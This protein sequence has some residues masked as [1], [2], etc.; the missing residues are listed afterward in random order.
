MQRRAPLAMIAALGL[1]LTAVVNVGYVFY[2]IFTFQPAPA[3]VAV[4]SASSPNGAATPSSKADAVASLD[5][6]RGRNLDKGVRKAVATGKEAVSTKRVSADANIDADRPQGSSLHAA[7]IRGNARAAEALLEAGADVNLRDSGGR[8][9][10]H[11]AATWGHADLMRRLLRSG[12]DA[13]AT[14]EGRQTALHMVASRRVP[15]L[16]VYADVARVLLENGARP[17][18]RDASGATPLALAEAAAARMTMEGNMK[19]AADA[20]EVARL[21]RARGGVE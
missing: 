4:A 19:A 18:V 17:N 16:A 12:A 1:L 10:L 2:L 9:P 13:N 6:A 3:R 8:T 11:V 7:A 5:D 20:K 14:A 21:I 15:P